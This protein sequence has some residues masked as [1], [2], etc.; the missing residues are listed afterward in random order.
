MGNYR[1]VLKKKKFTCSSISA[2]IAPKFIVQ[3]LL[4][5]LACF[6][7]QTLLLQLHPSEEAFLRD[8]RECCFQRPQLPHQSSAHPSSRAP[9][10]THG[11]GRPRQSSLRSVRL[12][13]F[14]HHLPR[15]QGTLICCFISSNS[16]ILS[17]F[18]HCQRVGRKRNQK[19]F[20]LRVLLT[21]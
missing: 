8:L 15:W 5:A 18:C 16:Q 19:P 21:F 10:H 3:C 12:A 2:L 11:Q 13:I 4:P 7:S 9:L 14:N 6:A 17:A 1:A 20:H